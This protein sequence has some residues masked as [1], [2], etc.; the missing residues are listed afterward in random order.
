MLIIGEIVC[1]EREK[2]NTGTLGTTAQVFY[3]PKSALKIKAIH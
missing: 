1:E 3:K 2:G